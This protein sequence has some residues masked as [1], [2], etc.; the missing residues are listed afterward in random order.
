VNNHY[1]SVSKSAPTG[2]AMSCPG[3]YWDGLSPKF[4]GRLMFGI[5]PDG[6]RATVSNKDLA[7]TDLSGYL[8]AYVISIQRY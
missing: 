7:E 8:T 4:K 2:W 6:N 1:F 3:G 5:Y